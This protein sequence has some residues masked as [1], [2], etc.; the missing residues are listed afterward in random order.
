MSKQAGTDPG[1][2]PPKKRK[3]TADGPD[4]ARYQVTLS[5][6]ALSNAQAIAEAHGITVGEACRRSLAVLKF[7]SDEDAKGGAFKLEGRNG[8]TERIRIVYA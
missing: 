8:V 3:T 7:L 6:E 2:A 4:T 5:G 1:D